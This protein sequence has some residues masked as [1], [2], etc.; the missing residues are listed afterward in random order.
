MTRI[1][2]I[3]N[4]VQ[5]VQNHLETP[6]V[7]LGFIGPVF[8]SSSP[9]GSEVENVF[10]RFL[11]CC[12]PMRSTL[13]SWIHHREGWIQLAR[14]C[15]KVEKDAGNS[16][17]VEAKMELFGCQLEQSSKSSWIFLISSLNLTWLRV[18]K[19]LRFVLKSLIISS[20]PANFLINYTLSK[21]VKNRL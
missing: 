15:P 10:F 17:K 12:S 11:Q 14:S 18:R 2:P 9:N 6:A 21:G 13:K 3:I 4:Y 16:A 19:Y 7:Q 8:R 1:S 5:Q 20:F